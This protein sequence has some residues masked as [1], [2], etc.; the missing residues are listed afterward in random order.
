[1]II[2]TLQLSGGVL[3]DFVF[4][5][6]T[7]GA[8][9]SSWMQLNGRPRRDAPFD[10]RLQDEDRSQCVDSQNYLTPNNQNEGI[11]SIT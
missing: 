10:L 6:Q 1:M 5:E 11:W 4:G 2:P 3:S 7:W 9:H 8:L